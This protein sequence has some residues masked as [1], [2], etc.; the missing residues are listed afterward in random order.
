MPPRREASNELNIND[1]H[2]VLGSESTFEGKLAFEGTVRID[3]KFKGEIHTDNTLV[4]GPSARVEATVHVGS[5]IVNGEVHGDVH[6]KH[7]IEI[8]APGKVR[9]NMS[10]PSLVIAKGVVFEGSCKMEDMQKSGNSNAGKPAGSG[11][12]T[13]T[14][15]VTLLSGERVSDDSADD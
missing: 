8:Q 14:A 4:V 5:I 1:V 13:S 15:S 2:T 9:G 3:G 7:S 6:A 11:S 12:S 10:T